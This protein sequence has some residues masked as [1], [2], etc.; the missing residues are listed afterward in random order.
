MSP[1][2]PCRGICAPE[3]A[4]EGPYCRGCLRTLKEIAEWAGATAQRKLEILNQVAGRV[5]VG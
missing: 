4:P 5:K 1:K 2:S 3:E